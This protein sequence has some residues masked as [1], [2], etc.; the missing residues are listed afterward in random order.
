[1]IEEFIQRKQPLYFLNP[2]P[3]FVAIFK[4]AGQEEFQYI[5]SSEDIPSLLEGMQNAID[6]K[7][8]Q[9][10]IKQNTYF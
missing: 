2:S 5:N 1:M 3:E 4:G 9:K 7:F 10:K 6:T 8:L